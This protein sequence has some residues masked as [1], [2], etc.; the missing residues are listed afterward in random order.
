MTIHRT[1]Y[2]EVEIEKVTETEAKLT[3]NGETLAW[4]DWSERDRIEK[5]FNRFLDKYKI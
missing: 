4:V 2:I 3:I 5:E 1:N